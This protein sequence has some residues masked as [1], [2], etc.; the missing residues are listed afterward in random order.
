MQNDGIPT[1]NRIMTSTSKARENG[2]SPVLVLSVVQCDHNTLGVL[3]PIPF[4][5][6]SS[7]SFNA[8]LMILLTASTWLLA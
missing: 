2:V 6:T 5:S 8:C 3:Q 7:F 4:F 1:S